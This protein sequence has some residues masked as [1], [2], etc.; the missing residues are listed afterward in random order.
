MAAKKMTNTGDELE[1]T[2]EVNDME[3]THAGLTPRSDDEALLAALREALATTL[4]PRRDELIASAQDA[5][6]FASITDEVAKLVFDSMWEDKLETASRAT[7]TSVRTLVFESD[8]LTL[9]IEVSSEGVVG[10]ITPGD[11]ATIEAE[12]SDGRRSGVQTDEFGWFSLPALGP[13][14]LRFHVSAGAAKAVTDWV[15]ATG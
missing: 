5:F 11:G 12:R 8:D 9:E 6:S 10:Q 4:H 7:A 13:G 15:N 3:S 14:P 1:N 2:R